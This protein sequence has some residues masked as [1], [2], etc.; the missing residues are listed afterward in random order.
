MT[1]SSLSWYFI[2]TRRQAMTDNLE[3]LGTILLTTTVRNEH[4]RIGGVVLEDHVMLEQFVQSLMAIDHVVYVMITASDGRSL[5][6]Q[7]KRSHRPSN[8][9]PQSSD[10]PFY[11]NDR[12]TESLLQAPLTAPLMSRLVLSSEQILIPQEESSD[13]LLPFLIRKETLYDFAMPVLRESLAKTLLPQF[14]VELEEKLS[15]TLA[16]KTP[17][18]VGL[19][20]IGITDAQAKQTLLL[21]IRNVLLLTLLIIAAGIL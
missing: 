10:Q 16:M 8:V 4:F 12:I 6:R 19:V 14:A 5:H 15:P 20:R 21:V 3:E 2:E 18:V 9:S 17:P 1:C 7:S 13:W 11:P